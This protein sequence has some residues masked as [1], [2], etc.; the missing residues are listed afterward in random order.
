MGAF[1]A[2]GSV[3]EVAALYIY[4]LKSAAGIA[5]TQAEVD[6]FGLRYD[7]RWMIADG[8]GRFISQREEPRLAQIVPTLREEALVLT[9]PQMEPLRLALDVRGQPPSVRVVVWDDDLIATPVG[10]AADRWASDFLGRRCR[11]V[12]IAPEQGRKLSAHAKV[13]FADAFPFLLVSEASLEDLNGRLARPVPMNRFR[14]NIVVRGVGPF[15]E[16]GWARIEIAG[17][18]FR[19]AKPCARCVITTT[20]QKTGVRAPD[21]E[22]LRT[23]ATY[24]RRGKDLLFGQNLLHEGRGMIKVGDIVRVFAR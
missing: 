22:P 7:W 1:G 24:R 21:A 9:A 23:L 18:T 14:P 11:L 12:Y 2:G 4:P 5:L 6:E 17:I 13:G 20:D 8:N 15:A 10:D 16:D 3:V 19:V